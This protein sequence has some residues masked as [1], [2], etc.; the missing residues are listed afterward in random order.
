MEREREREREREME[1]ERERERD[2]ERERESYCKHVCVRQCHE[3]SLFVYHCMCMSF[4]C[5][6][7]GFRTRMVHLY[8]ISCLRY[9]ILV[10]NPQC[11]H[12]YYSYTFMHECVRIHCVY[13]F[14]CIVDMY[15]H[16]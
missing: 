3:F 2:G 8:Y 11:A 12:A 5:A 13:V 7:R 6:Y 14:V 1:R 4:L 16:V 10:R 9:T 15:I